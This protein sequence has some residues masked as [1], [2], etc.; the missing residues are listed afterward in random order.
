MKEIKYNFKNIFCLLLPFVL[1]LG[2]N[3]T[4]DILIQKESFAP[5]TTFQLLPPKVLTDS[6]FF[7]KNTKV[8]LAM[9]FSGTEIRY[10][11]DGSPVTKKSPLYLEPLRIEKTSELQTLA[12]HP[13]CKNSL[14]KTQ[15]LYNAVDVFSQAKIVLKPGIDPRYPANGVASLTD[16]QKGSNQFRV[17][18]RWLGF[19]KDTVSI[20]VE[21]SEKTSLES[22][23]VST[24]ANE[25][26]WI[27]VPKKVELL[28]GETVFASM[29]KTALANASETGSHFIAVDFPEREV[30]YL[31]IRVLSDWLPEGHNGYGYI[32]W[33]F[34]D[35]II[36]LSTK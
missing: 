16:L 12:F 34:I 24:F 19:Q 21:F 6:V 13:D 9:G 5:A 31:T 32:S 20:K 28:E 4:N 14:V 11:L 10:T 33:L 3:S 8:E 1:L 25:L 26:A 22:I 27:F 7:R 23:I 2:C 29:D 36:A 18:K 30:K 35:E 17:D 15:T